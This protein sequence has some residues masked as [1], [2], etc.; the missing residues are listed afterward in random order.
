MRE[1]IAKKIRRLSEVE[2]LNYKRL[3][4]SYYIAKKEGIFKERRLSE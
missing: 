1:K 4:K 2:D 3:K